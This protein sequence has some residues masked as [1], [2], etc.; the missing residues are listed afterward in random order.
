MISKFKQSDGYIWRYDSDTKECILEHRYVM[1]QHLGRKLKTSETVHHKDHNKENNSIE[2]LEIIDNAEHARMH[3]LEHGRLYVELR[4]P[5][6]G[7][8]FETPKTQ[9]YLQKRNKYPCTCCSPRCRGLLY[10]DI[11]MYGMTDS[12]RKSMSNS[13]IREFVKYKK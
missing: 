6:C 7:I 9:S 5:Q 2:N 13:F 4:C 3:Q 11:Q 10:K 8:T 1:E 12:I